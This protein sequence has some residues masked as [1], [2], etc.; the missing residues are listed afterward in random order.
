M[1]KLDLEFE[2]RKVRVR[3]TVQGVGFRPTV[4][5]LAIECDLNGDV[6]ND[7]DGVLMHLSGGAGNIQHF[8]QRLKDESPPLAKI[9]AIESK[10]V[11]AQ[12]QF[13]DFR[14]NQSKLSQGHTEVTADAATCSACL[15]EVN[16]AGERRF[17]YPFT[18]CTHCGPRLSIVQ[19][20]PYDRGNTT[21]TDFPLCGSCSAEYNNPMDR[22]FHAQPI[23]CHD[24]GPQL[25]LH[26]SEQDE[27]DNQSLSVQ[28]K[29]QQIL[30]RIHCALNAGKIIALKG[31]G[32]F[33]LCCDA[34]NHA[35]V[36]QLRQRK[37][38]YA[39]PFALMSH[40]IN[41]IE[42]YCYLSAAE[43]TTL[44]SPAAPIVLLQE[45]RPTGASGLSAAIAPGSQLL[46]FML[47]YTPLHA[48]ICQQFA[49]PLVMTSGNLSGDPQIIDNQ[50]AIEKLSGIADLIV[51]HDR[52]IANRIDDSVLRVISGKPRIMRRARG[53]APRSISLPPGFEQANAILAYGA[54]LKS[55]FCLVKQGAAILSQH[56]GDLENLST[57]D[58]Y[59]HNLAL[60]KQLFEFQ[61]TCLA[62]DK[63]PEY[64]SSKLAL[65]DASIHQL[66]AIAVQ[67]HHAHI[68]SVMVENQVPLTHEAVLG[69]ALDGLG[70]GSDGNLWGGEFL[71]ADY[72]Q[73]QRVARLKPVV[74]PGGAQAVKQ[75]W[76]NTY[77]Q[78]LNSMSW[79]AF[80]AGY[81]SIDLAQ[82]LK[83][84]PIATLDAMF[85][86]Q[87]NCPLVS[88]T[89]RL[90]DA[91]AGALGISTEQVQFEG[92][93]AIEL[94]M[95]AD[96]DAVVKQT[97]TRP[98]DLKL[99]QTQQNNAH[100][101]IELNPASIWPSLL[102]DLAN[103]ETL[104][105]ISSR[106][107]A[108]LINSIVQ[109]IA[110]LQQQ[111]GF[112]KVA[113]SGGCL[114][115]ALLLQ[116]LENALTARQLTTLSHAAVPANDGGIALGQA[117]IAAARMIKQTFN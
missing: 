43:K 78:I 12:W 94:E 90:F 86:K 61:P 22:R 106:F 23:A 83:S 81:G 73:F 82:T 42:N 17:A 27:V 68:T 87:L 20:I 62:Y 76:R 80:I 107:H 40:D 93:A 30:N 16:D 75:P 21:M 114:Q 105:T 109:V 2:N 51:Y 100:P 63:H 14:I 53:Y 77:A 59:E 35:T 60:Y 69:V 64:L 95:L 72:C 7:T 5:R 10:V 4:Y 89:G 52:D 19:G 96:N 55:T 104:S 18:N 6:S 37:N 25:F 29:N 46:G 92:Q 58:D 13:D 9:D 71:L 8:L 3:G 41:D 36:S 70:F 101:L 24:C 57:F 113:L 66:P 39:K 117:A 56:Q 33:H 102:H 108:G 84:M 54:E 31:L 79:E 49:R 99:T 47:P 65:K 28:A 115:N 116:G 44:N 15:A 85:A 32:G 67:H 98:Y 111:H 112:T 97:L 26:T 103:Q 45:K 110:T 1:T 48:L 91:V 11:D 34:S 88:S 50:E 38:R 74:M